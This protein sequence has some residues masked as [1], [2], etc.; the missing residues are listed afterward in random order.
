MT[1][2]DQRVGRQDERVEDLELREDEARDIAGGARR[3][4]K[5]EKKGGLA[6]T[7]SRSL[8]SRDS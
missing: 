5:A 2:Q 4:K 6:K 1:D 8:Q 7:Q 3:H